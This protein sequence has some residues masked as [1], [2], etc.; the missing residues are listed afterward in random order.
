MSRPSFISLNL[1]L[2]LDKSVNIPSDID[3]VLSLFAYKV[4]N[5]SA[6]SEKQKME[7]AKR[8]DKKRKTANAREREEADSNLAAEGL[9]MLSNVQTKHDA[10]DQTETPTAVSETTRTMNSSQSVSIQ[11]ALSG[12]EV[13]DVYPSRTALSTLNKITAT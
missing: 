13:T 4:Q 6:T 12:R 3:Y 8:L 2:K 7:C 9:L 10:A 5:H 1:I 11:T